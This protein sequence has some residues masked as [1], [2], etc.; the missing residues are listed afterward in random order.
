MHIVY[1]KKWTKLFT[2]FSWLEG[3][4]GQCNYNICVYPQDSV[5]LVVIVNDQNL[6]GK[7]W[8]RTKFMNE[9]KERDSR[10]II[11][12]FDITT[13]GSGCYQSPFPNHTTLWGLQC[14]ILKTPLMVALNP[15]THLCQWV[16]PMA[17]LY[18]RIPT[19]RLGKDKVK[20]KRMG[21]TVKF[22]CGALPDEI[23]SLHLYNM[24]RKKLYNER[25]KKK[26]SE[27]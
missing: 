19:H 4:E 22:F 6:H 11:T 17:K 26:F 1:L 9:R 16:E 14:Y 18:Q 21:L 13:F 23:I 3:E 7:H 8:G 25:D 27:V 15:R 20:E 2:L 12:F 24:K 5:T 10:K